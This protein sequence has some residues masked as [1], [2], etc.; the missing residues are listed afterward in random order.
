[1]QSF[2]TASN[3]L[4]KVVVEPAAGLIGDKRLMI[5]ADGALNYIPF[6]VLLKTPD[7]G[8]FSSLGYLIKSNEIIY[9]PSASVVGAITTA[10]CSAN[11]RA[12]LNS[13]LIAVFNFNDRRARKPA[14]RAQATL[15]F[16]AWNPPGRPRGRCRDAYGTAA[17]LQRW[18]DCHLLV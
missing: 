11:G 9:A 1:M 3:A 12:M 15:K 16:A 7:S 8:D 10:A 18:K 17:S 13:L 4:Y 5:V 2:V 6:E 14:G